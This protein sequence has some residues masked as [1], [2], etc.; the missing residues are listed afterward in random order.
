MTKYLLYFALIFC[1]G[2]P[3]AIRA[4][5]MGTNVE[6]KKFIFPQYREKDSCLQFIVHGETAENRGA[7]VYLTGM[8]LDIVND[9]VKD[10]ADVKLLENVKP[11]PLLSSKST[12]QDFWKDKDHTRA[13]V[14][15]EKSVLDKNEKVMRSD[16][17]VFFRSPEMDADGV[18]F[19]AYHDRKYVTINSNVKVVIRPEARRRRPPVPGTVNATAETNETK[20]ANESG[21]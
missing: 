6:V 13:L 4:Q 18:G 10:I 20:N 3:M 9:A 15:S 5:G 17:R 16:G 21:K 19:T 1:I 7:F 8:F 2:M 12:S 11:Y 14:F